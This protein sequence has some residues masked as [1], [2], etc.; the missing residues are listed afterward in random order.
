MILIISCITLFA[1]WRSINYR[2]IDRKTHG[3][4]VSNI[5]FRI[6]R[7]ISF[8]FSCSVDKATWIYS[9]LRCYWIKE[10]R[11]HN[12]FY[13]NM[14]TKLSRYIIIRV[15]FNLICLIG[16][17]CHVFLNCKE[18]L[19]YETTAIIAHYIPESQKIPR[20]SLC[21]TFDLDKVQNQ[22]FLDHKLKNNS[23]ALSRKYSF[24]SINAS[25]IVEKCISRDLEK[26]LRE[27]FNCN[28]LFHVRK[29]HLRYYSC[30]L[31][32]P[33]NSQ[34]YDL[35]KMVASIR[36][37]SFLYQ[38]SLLSNMTKSGR[39]LPMIHFKSWPFEEFLYAMDVDTSV[40]DKQMYYL[41]YE[42]V[43]FL[44]LPHPYDTNCVENYPTNC[45]FSRTGH[46]ARLKCF[47]NRCFIFDAK[48]SR[49]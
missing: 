19:K 36:G 26:D 47:E 10:Q 42:L 22:T 29:T 39:I 33:R 15:L 43:E 7:N 38:L 44:R 24:S 13:F 37:K 35:L 25:S 27:E 32:T 40:G 41:T 12:S 34:S 1:I 9:L 2:S 5:K 8:N 31:L 46:C 16:C 28:S 4:F 11:I 20:T 23:L 3:R 17:L 45:S 21:F 48:K 18:Y 14:A 30:Y 6:L 49:Y